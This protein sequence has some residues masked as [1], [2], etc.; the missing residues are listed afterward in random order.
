LE[1][2]NDKF[3]ATFRWDEAGLRDWADRKGELS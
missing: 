1:F 3:N 2:D